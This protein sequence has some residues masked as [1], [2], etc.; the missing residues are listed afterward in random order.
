MAAE[1]NYDMTV[2]RSLQQTFLYCRSVLERNLRMYRPLETSPH[3][4]L[5]FR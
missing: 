1:L 4:D 3:K 2:L 5:L